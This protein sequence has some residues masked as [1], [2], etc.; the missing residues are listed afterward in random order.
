MFS[1]NFCKNSRT[2]IICQ[3]EGLHELEKVCVALAGSC[4]CCQCTKN[5]KHVAS[6]NDEPVEPH[7][8]ILVFP[9]PFC[10]VENLH[11]TSL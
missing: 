9:S 3:I 4:H 10:Q 2:G 8:L 6:R 5:I 1:H 11:R 7:A